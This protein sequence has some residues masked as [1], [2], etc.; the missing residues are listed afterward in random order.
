MMNQMLRPQSSPAWGIEGGFP[1]Q[2]EFN[3]MYKCGETFS[4]PKRV[5][6]CFRG[7]EE[8]EWR[9]GSSECIKGM[10]KSLS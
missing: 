3:W 5:E 4:W 1:K 2:I 10:K 6:E 8:T 7:S 9:R